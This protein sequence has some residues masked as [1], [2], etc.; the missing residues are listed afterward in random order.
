[1]LFGNRRPRISGARQR[2]DSSYRPGGERL[3]DKLLLAIDLGGVPPPALPNVAVAN[4]ANTPTGPFGGICGQEHLDLSVGR[5]DGPDVATLGHPVAET[6][7]AALLGHHRGTDDRVRGR[8][9][10][11]L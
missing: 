10:C 3:E 6:E 2:S 8:A 9:R 7:Q 11:R 1:M 5:H 4:A